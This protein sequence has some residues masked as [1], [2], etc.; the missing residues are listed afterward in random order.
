MSFTVEI[1]LSQTLDDSFTYLCDEQDIADNK[2]LIGQLCIVPFRNKEIAGIIVAL[3]Q[4]L[5][6]MPKFKLKRIKK[7]LP[8]EPLTPENLKFINQFAAYNMI[9]RG[10]VLKMMISNATM[11]QERYQS[12]YQLQ[13]NIDEIARQNI[14]LTKARIQLLERAKNL[15]PLPCKILAEQTGVSENIIKKMA[16]SGIFSIIQQKILPDLPELP[17]LNFQKMTLS[18]PQQTAWDSI[19]KNLNQTKPILLD[20]ETGSGKTVLYFE[21]VAQILRQNRQALI[22]LPEIILTQQFVQYF[23][24]RFKNL[25]LLWHSAQSPK[26]RAEIWQAALIGK[27]Y[28]FIGARSSLLLP[29]QNLGLI[30]VDEE[31][32]SSY[33]QYENH[34]YHARDMAVLRA[35]ISQIPI[36]LASA[37]SSL[38]SQINMEKNRYQH[39]HLENRYRDVKLADVTLV[40]LRREKLQ[41][42]KFLATPLIENLAK[43]LQAGK[44]SI[45]FLN[46]RGFAPLLLCQN[47]GFR[48]ICPD[49]EA[50]M[51]V[52][53]KASHLACHHCGFKVNIPTKCKKCGE[54]EGL[55]LY[56]PGIERIEAE[57]KTLFPEARTAMMASDYIKNAEQAA[58]II[59][60]MKEGKIDILIGT[61]ILTK[62]YHFPNLTFVGVVDADLSLAGGDL[63]AGERTYQ[64]LHQVMGRAGR[65]IQGHA[66]LQTMYPDHI[67]FQALQTQDRESFYEAEKKIRKQGN[68]PPYGR[69]AMVLLSAKNQNLLN[70][71]A[72]TLKRHHQKIDGVTILGPA[73]PQ[74]AKLKGK[75]QV[76]FLIKTPRNF[77]LQKFLRDWLSEMPRP[78][79]VAMKIDIDPL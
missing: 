29:F 70:D 10:A 50:S 23:Q 39:V 75:W 45:L 4:L 33:K 20:G 25:P 32:D 61:Q 48:F 13:M 35:K 78:S 14:K 63:R 7:I 55:M 15:A 9:A 67:L 37:T 12:C 66:M 74:I 18:A 77:N 1:L 49:C 41:A 40:D 62:G 36:I 34:V 11:F 31:H 26:K 65:E 43:N 19:S 52:H 72:K 46:R 22:L 27:P 71:Y 47:C 79:S 56:G 24:D 5:T 54:E 21:A 3:P 16:D 59:T 51:V 69:M 57:V 8:F 2:L 30:V 53:Q 60:A 17:E 73:A 42:G 44:Q 58:E 68:W 38:E 28:C 76:N 64:L 6:E